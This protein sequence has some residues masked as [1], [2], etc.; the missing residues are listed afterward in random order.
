[1]LQN[2]TKLEDDNLQKNVNSLVPVVYFEMFSYR[3]MGFTYSNI[4]ARTGYS[5]THVR[6]LFAQDGAIHDLWLQWVITE[7]KDLVKRSM[8]MMFS[9]LPEIIENLIRSAKSDHFASI[10]AAKLILTYVV[11]VPEKKVAV[12]IEEKLQP[13]SLAGWVMTETL[14]QQGASEE[15]IQRHLRNMRKNNA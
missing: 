1:M 7:R 15:E 2:D 6:R 8:D 12:E 4:A 3:L 13:I 14:R 11:G 9:A 10:V 5:E